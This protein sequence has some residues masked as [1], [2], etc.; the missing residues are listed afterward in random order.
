M[1]HRSLHKTFMSKLS[2]FMHRACAEAR[3]VAKCGWDAS[4]ESHTSPVRPATMPLGPAHCMPDHTPPARKAASGASSATSSYDASSA[5]TLTSL[6][7]QTY[8]L[9]LG[10]AHQTS[11]H[12]SPAW[13]VTC[14]ATSVTSPNETSAMGFPLCLGRQ[15]GS[16]TRELRSPITVPSRHLKFNRFLRTSRDRPCRYRCHC[17]GL[18]CRVLT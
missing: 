13:M 14:D 7:A 18:P 15:L 10:P 1:P 11:D 8:S 3:S 2:D 16:P 12:A 6:P 5:P 17:R 4:T 9:T